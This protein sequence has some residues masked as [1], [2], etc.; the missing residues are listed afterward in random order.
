MADVGLEADEAHIEA[1]SDKS[2]QA[3]DLGQIQA[4]G[5]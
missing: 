1:V 5:R 3:D 4:V 2:E